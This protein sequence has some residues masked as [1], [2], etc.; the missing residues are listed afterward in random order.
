MCAEL[1]DLQDAIGAHTVAPD[2]R[3]LG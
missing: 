2:T 1:L 3:L